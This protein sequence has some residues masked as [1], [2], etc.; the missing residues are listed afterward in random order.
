MDPPEMSDPLAEA[1]GVA[2]T[3]DHA[4]DLVRG[5][6]TGVHRHRNPAHVLPVLPDL[7]E[8]DAP[9]RGLVQGSVVGGGVDP[10]QPG[11]FASC[12]R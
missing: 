8:V 9:A 6:L 5:D 2:V 10:P 4:R 3:G 12:G 1:G 7:V 11:R